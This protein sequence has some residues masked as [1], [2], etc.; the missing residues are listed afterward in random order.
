MSALGYAIASLR[1]RMA[2]LC[3]GDHPV[4]SNHEQP[5]IQGCR[6]LSGGSTSQHY[7]PRRRFN[8]Q[9]TANYISR[10]CAPAT[11][12]P[13]SLDVHSANVWNS[14]AALSA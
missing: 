14:M 10:Y 3:C 11:P 4:A 12:P 7:V 1:K 2:P 5:N 13:L 9:R 8:Q 6:P